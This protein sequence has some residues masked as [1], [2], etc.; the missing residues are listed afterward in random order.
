MFSLGVALHFRERLILRMGDFLC[1]VG[2]NFCDR[3]GLFFLL[4]ISFC[5]LQEVTFHGLP[6]DDSF[7]SH[8]IVLFLDERGILGRFL[9][10]LNGHQM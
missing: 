8:F 4:G 6:S 1:F 3:E 5:V 9:S 7:V 2:N 10:E